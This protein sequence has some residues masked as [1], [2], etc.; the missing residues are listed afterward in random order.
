MTTTQHQAWSLTWPTEHGWYWTWKPGENGKPDRM[1]PA[2]VTSLGYGID[3]IAIYA[4]DYPH[5]HWG[6][7]IEAPAAPGTRGER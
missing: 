1:E 2:Q 4:R 3:G 5:L 7:R 6:P